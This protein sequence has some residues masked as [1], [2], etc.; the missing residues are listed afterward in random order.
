VTVFHRGLDLFVVPGAVPA[1]AYAK[2]G[3]STHGV[4]HA[5]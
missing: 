5:K 1:L 3:K 4:P 2:S